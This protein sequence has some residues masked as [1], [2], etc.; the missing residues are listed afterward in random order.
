MRISKAQA[1]ANHDR[2]VEVASELFRERGFDGVGVS[3]LMKAAGFTHGGF[4]NHFD[5]KEA[6]TVEAVAHAFRASAKAGAGERDL[7][8]VLTDYLS[9][10][11]RRA[12]GR[13]CPAAALG[14]DAG[15]QPDSIKAAFADGAEGMIAGL[16]R[17]RSPE[18]DGAA[19]ARARD[20]NLLAKMVG[21]L[22]LARAAPA[23]SPLGDEI[24]A[25]ALE[26]CLREAGLQPET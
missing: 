2:V 23:D 22:I 17:M 8:T 24:L 9:P 13:G 16:A 18:T 7:R 12:L 6:L 19:A 4:Y 26:G 10:A 15:R 3:E 1:A 20:I 14:C 11:H 21:A 25:A 5:S